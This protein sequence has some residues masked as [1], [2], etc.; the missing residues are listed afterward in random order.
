MGEVLKTGSEVVRLPFGVSL[1][2]VQKT[3]LFRGRVVMKRLSHPPGERLSGS[4]LRQAS[5]QQGDQRMSSEAIA[6]CFKSLILYPQ[7]GHSKHVIYF[8][9]LTL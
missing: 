8:P 5:S 4:G 7:L 2:T 9:V 3:E 6:P 1:T